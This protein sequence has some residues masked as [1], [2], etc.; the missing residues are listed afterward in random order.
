M[1]ITL[2]GDSI[3]VSIDGK[4]VSHFDGDLAAAR[5]RTIWHEPKREPKR[6]RSGFIR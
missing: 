1:I 2:K 4:A 5:E 3:D 6:P